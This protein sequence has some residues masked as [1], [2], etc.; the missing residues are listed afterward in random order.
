MNDFSEFNIKPNQDR[1]IGDK[2]KMMQV[3]NREIIVH[4]FKINESKFSDTSSGICLSLQI[5]IN[6][7]NR[8]LFTGSR[9]LT[10]MIKQVPEDA[11]PFKTI[12]TKE[13]ES[14]QFN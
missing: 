12:I 8:V 2:I 3:L 13:G 1:L 7:E 6:N 4:R 9:I 11:L 10:E 14:Y 5:E